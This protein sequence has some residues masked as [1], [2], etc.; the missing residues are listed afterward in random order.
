MPEVDQYTFKHQE[1]IEALIKKAGLHEGKWQLVM[2][3]GLAGLNMGPSPGEVMPGAAVG[4]VS[5]GLQRAKPDSP[6]SLVADAAVVN[7]SST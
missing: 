7:P 3:F 1:V 6:E 5:I 2:Q 4:V